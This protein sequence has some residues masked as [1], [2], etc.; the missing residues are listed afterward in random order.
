MLFGLSRLEHII[1]DTCSILYTGVKPTYH[2]PLSRGT[3]ILRGH[4]IYQITFLID[5]LLEKF[6]DTYHIQFAYLLQH[7]G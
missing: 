4:H 6:L 7:G 1:A 3:S 5:I 2:I